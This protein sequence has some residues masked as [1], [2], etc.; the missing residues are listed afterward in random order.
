MVWIA[1]N[2]E[3]ERIGKTSGRGQFKVLSQYLH[4]E[5]EESKEKAH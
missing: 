4:L 1:V 2:N 5:T 3:Y